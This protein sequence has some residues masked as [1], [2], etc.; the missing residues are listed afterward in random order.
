MFQDINPTEFFEQQETLY[1]VTQPFLKAQR[2]IEN[3]FSMGGRYC[4][5]YSAALVT[6]FDGVSP[7]RAAWVRV[8]GILGAWDEKIEAVARRIESLCDGVFA[9][10]LFVARAAQ[11][12][13]AI[14]ALH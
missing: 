2:A 1:L 12:F 11:P 6:A 13:G 8:G 5:F 14:G 7:R 3:F 4:S 10:S 9:C